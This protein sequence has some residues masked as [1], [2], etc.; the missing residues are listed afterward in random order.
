M[1]TSRRARKVAQAIRQVVGMSILSE[2]KDPRVK[3][4]TLTRVEVTGD[5]REAKVY[6]SVMGD[7]HQQELSLQG[8]QSAAG[9]LQ[10]KCAE[11]IDMRYTPRLHFQF[12]KGI[13]NAFEVSR[14]LNE[15]L[16][17]D[18]PSPETP[19]TMENEAAS[20]ETERFSKED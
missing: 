5:L 1:S 2:L 13:K 17:H 7:E 4:V 11:R 20:E 9:F 8:L 16:P 15:V 14:I 18:E 6:V 10:A 19:E 3:D 12:D